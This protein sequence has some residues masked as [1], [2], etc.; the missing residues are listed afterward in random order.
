MAASTDTIRLG[1]MCTCNSYRP[2]AYMANVATTVDVWA[3][4]QGPLLHEETFKATCHVVSL[5]SSGTRTTRWLR[6]V[7]D[8]RWGVL[9]GGVDPV[10]FAAGVGE[11]AVGF[12]RIVFHRMDAEEFPVL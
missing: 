1:Q 3:R 11:G 10:G 5:S 12:D 8:P 7:D 9:A 2:P 6:L 4:H